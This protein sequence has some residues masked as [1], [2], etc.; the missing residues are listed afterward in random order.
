CRT[1]SRLPRN[2]GREAQGARRK[3]R[4]SSDQ[5]ANRREAGQRHSAATTVAAAVPGRRYGLA[6][7]RVVQPR[8]GFERALLTFGDYSAVGCLLRWLRVWPP[9]QRS[10]AVQTA[11]LRNTIT[12]AN[13]RTLI[14]SC[15]SNGMPRRSV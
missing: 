3:R 9:F 14:D 13:S 12:S 7:A 4:P 5:A 6:A 2:A 8:D 1:T 15:R 10:P 11:A